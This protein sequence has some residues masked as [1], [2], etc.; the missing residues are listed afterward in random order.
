MYSH[1][2]YTPLTGFKQILGY[3]PFVDIFYLNTCQDN[4]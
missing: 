4:H 2:P 1:L 3:Y